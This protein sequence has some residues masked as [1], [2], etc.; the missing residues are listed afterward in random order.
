MIGHAQDRLVILPVD[1]DFNGGLAVQMGIVDEVADHA[2]QQRR[3]PANGHRPSLHPA[4]VVSRAFLRR[5][6]GEIDVLDPGG[7]GSVTI[8]KPITL[9]GGSFVASVL[10]TGVQGIVISAKQ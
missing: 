2:T 6:G 3:V 5:E 1:G 8:T 9:D 4:V 10:N 7:F